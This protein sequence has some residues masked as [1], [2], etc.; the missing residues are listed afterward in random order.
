MRTVFTDIS[1]AIRKACK[2][3]ILASQGGT[4]E[5]WGGGKAL[6]GLREVLDQSRVQ[7]NL[8]CRPGDLF[9]GEDE[10][11]PTFSGQIRICNGEWQDIHLPAWFFVPQDFLDIADPTVQAQCLAQLQ[12]HRSSR[13]SHLTIVQ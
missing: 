12:S 6:A 1:A 4:L 5:T 7:I 3:V 13:S 8:H 9:L 10:F 11:V 2:N